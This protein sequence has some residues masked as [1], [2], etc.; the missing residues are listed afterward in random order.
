MILQGVKYKPGL[1]FWA[2][3]CFLVASALAGFSTMSVTASAPGSIP[4]NSWRELHN[5]KNILPPN[6]AFYYEFP[7]SNASTAHLVVA[8]L[9]E[10]KWRFRPLILEKTRT[11]SQAAAEQSASAAVNGGYFNLSDGMS[12]GY[13]VIDGMMLADPHHNHAL[14]S[15][16]KLHDFLPQIFNRSELRVLRQKGQKTWEIQIAKHQ[17]P[18]PEGMELVDSLQAGPRLLPTLDAEEE[19]FLRRQSDGTIVDSIGCRKPAARTAFGITPDGYGML[20]AVSGKG[21]DK[22]SA[23]ITL[24]QLA[25][26]LRRLGCRQAI[27]LDGGSSTTMYVRLSNPDSSQGAT[28]CSKDPETLVKTILMLQPQ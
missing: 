9:R 1:R 13:V 25:D 3:L 2:S 18:L 15:N 5:Q 11:T 19:A 21:Q 20:L 24:E 28:V 22:E 26:L 16:P 8:Y 4:R 23:G 17:D 10:S 27:N 12:A 14:I 7:L 6:G